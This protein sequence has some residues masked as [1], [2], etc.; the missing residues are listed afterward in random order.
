M[1]ER[2]FVF[3]DTCANR[4]T[5]CEAGWLKFRC[6]CYR[7]NKERKSWQE[8]Q[9]I[10]M[11]SEGNLVSIHHLAELEFI[12]T[13]VKLGTSRTSRGKQGCILPGKSNP[14]TWATQGVL[15]WPSVGKSALQL[16]SLHC[17]C[18]SDAQ[19]SVRSVLGRATG[20]LCSQVSPVIWPC[21]ILCLRLT[22]LGYGYVHK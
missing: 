3:L 1:N 10:C 17:Q 20:H 8:S 2:C 12:L 4:T 9:K 13:R 19:D 16:V 7:L 14:T 21:M 15:L 5:T 11:R 22:M 6:N 18:P